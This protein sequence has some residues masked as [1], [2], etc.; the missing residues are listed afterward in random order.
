MGMDRQKE[1]T[2]KVRF[3][4]VGLGAGVNMYVCN[5]KYLAS[6]EIVAVMDVDPEAVRRVQEKYGIPHGFTDLDE[7]LTLKELDAVIICTPPVFHAQQVCAAAKAG[8]H[9]LCDKPMAPTVEECRQMIRCCEENGVYLM[10]CFMKHFD[11]GMRKVK[12]LI[13]AGAI[14]AVQQ[15]ITKWTWC[16]GAY[17]EGKAPWRNRYALTHGGI[18][19]DHGPHVLDLCR[20]WMGEVESVSAEVN[21]LHEG[22]EVES[23]AAVI[24]RHASGAISIHNAS[25]NCHKELTEYYLID[26]ATGSIE[27]SFDHEWS[28]N[29][30]YP[31]R[32]YL[33]RN[34]VSREDITVP[35]QGNMDTEFETNGRYRNMMEYFCRCVLERRAPEINTGYDG[36]KAMEVVDAVYLSSH[37][38]KKIALPLTAE[39]EAQLDLQ[40]IFDAAGR[41]SPEKRKW[42]D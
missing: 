14:G 21:I 5:E 10:V 39:D 13:D 12:A 27:I 16:E 36:L 4:L 1:A 19:Q 38:G 15:V 31:F 6:G 24:C 33:Y 2:G 30:P 22:Y 42:G 28:F 41:R 25:R 17:E 29:N 23:N 32:M 11:A 20:W 34:G 7:M 8:K 37:L 35:Q 18:F 40:A 9:V 26:G 3:G